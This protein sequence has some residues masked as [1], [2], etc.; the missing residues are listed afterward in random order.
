MTLTIRTS[1]RLR[2]ALERRAREHGTSVSQAARDIL[3]AALMPRPLA[4]RTGHLRGSLRVGERR[5]EPWRVAS[6]ERN[7]RE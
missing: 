4:A 5:P 3:T 6:R 7:W 1:E 2:L